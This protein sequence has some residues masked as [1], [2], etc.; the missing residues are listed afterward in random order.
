MT[1]SFILQVKVRAEMI[2]AGACFLILKKESRESVKS[3]FCDRCKDGVK[4]CHN[5]IR[6][7]ALEHFEEIDQIQIYIIKNMLFHP[8]LQFHIYSKR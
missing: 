2:L 4:F 1:L 5:T 6:G 7:G 3:G 8:R